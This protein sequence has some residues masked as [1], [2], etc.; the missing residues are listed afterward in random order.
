MILR[1]IASLFL[2][3]NFK[4]PKLT[5]FFTSQFASSLELF[6]SAAPAHRCFSFRHL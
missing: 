2:R 6:F 5:S 1:F 3:V 4:D